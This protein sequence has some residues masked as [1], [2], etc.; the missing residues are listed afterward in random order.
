M[1]AVQ[2]S[3]DTTNEYGSMTFTDTQK[4][5]LAEKLDPARV[6]KNPKGFDH[7]E[8]WEV[9]QKA[10]EIFGFDGWCRETLEMEYLHQPI[11]NKNNNICVSYRARVRITVGDVVR[12]GTG[13]GNGWSAQE[14]DAHESAVKEAETDATKRAFMTFGNQF[15][16]ALYDKAKENVKTIADGYVEVALGVIE[17]TLKTREGAE[18]WWKDEAQHRREHN[19]TQEHVNKLGAALKAKFPPE[20]EAA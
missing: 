14:T 1:Q 20:K 8:G 3:G 7:L 17:H 10:N 18:Q 6:K 5:T 12:E 4:K 19:L 15:G 2:A 16:L 11:T 9:I 13:F